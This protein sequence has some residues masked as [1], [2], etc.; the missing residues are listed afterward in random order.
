M[1]RWEEARMDEEGNVCFMCCNKCYF[2]INGFTN[3]INHK[4]ETKT[5]IIHKDGTKTKTTKCTNIQ[6]NLPTLYVLWF[7]QDVLPQCILLFRYD[8]WTK[9]KHTLQIKKHHP[10]NDSISVKHH[11]TASITAEKKKS[12]PTNSIN[13][14]F[15]NRSVTRIP[16]LQKHICTPMHFCVLYISWSTCNAVASM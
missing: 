15:K 5:V 6:I 16:G 10:T 13:P 14:A 8:Y 1:E 2:C 9:L 12:R 7:L 3:E 11:W 4:Q